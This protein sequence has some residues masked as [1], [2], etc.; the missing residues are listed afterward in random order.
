MVDRQAGFEPKRWR[1]TNPMDAKSDWQ[2][3]LLAMSYMMVVL[4]VM[5]TWTYWVVT[6][7]EPFPYGLPVLTSPA[8]IVVFVVGVHRD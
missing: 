5:S 2:A 4:T 3:G 1:L 7:F 6:T 8:W